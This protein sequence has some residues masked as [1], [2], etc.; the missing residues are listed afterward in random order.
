M[1]R[2]TRPFRNRERCEQG[3][4]FLWS[5]K[6]DGEGIDACQ[7]GNSHFTLIALFCTKILFHL[8][9]IAIKTPARVPCFLRKGPLFLGRVGLGVFGQCPAYLHSKND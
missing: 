5:E 8:P 4:S 3:L 9:R 6:S 2:G 1:A 7:T